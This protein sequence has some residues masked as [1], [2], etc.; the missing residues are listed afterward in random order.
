VSVGAM[1]VARRWQKMEVQMRR[2][3]RIQGRP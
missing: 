1:R 2:A 3:C